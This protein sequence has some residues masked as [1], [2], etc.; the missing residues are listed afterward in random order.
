MLRLRGYD[1][2]LIVVLHNNGA[3]DLA[4]PS[5]HSFSRLREKAQTTIAA[6]YTMELGEQQYRKLLQA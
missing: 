3:Y 6:N 4:Y 5:P 2:G 1:L